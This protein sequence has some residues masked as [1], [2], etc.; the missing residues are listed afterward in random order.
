MRKIFTTILA[1]ALIFSLVA[2]GSVSKTGIDYADAESF[3]AAL[4][5]GE[6]LEG[7]VVQFVAKELYPN[8]A[9]GYIVHAGDH[10]NFAS[11]KNPDIKVGDTVVVKATDISSLLGSWIIT[12]EKV[13]NAKITDATISSTSSSVSTSAD[14][15][16]SNSNSGDNTNS[17][18]VASSSNANTK[19]TEQ[20]LQ[21]VDHGCALSSTLGDTAYIDFCGMIYNPNASL[22]VEFPKLLVTVKNGDGSI[23]ATDS[24]TGYLI[25]PGDTITLCGTFAMPIADLTDDAVIY[26]DIEWG[27]FYSESASAFRRAKTTD[28][29][30]SNISERNGSWN[31]ITG[32]ITNNYSENIDM[33]DVVVILRKDGEIVYIDHTYVD[34]VKAGQTKAFE[35]KS[36]KNWP[37]HDTIDIS[38]SPWM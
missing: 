1:V 18:R 9:L 35:F 3:E 11:S 2:C 31:Y 27:D 25:Q 5:A 19:P 15:S 36:Y 38:C 30:V 20:P 10:L 34:S 13:N 28:F 22:I 33:V 29:V 4:D 26:Y 14:E 32:E 24:Q 8:S 21:I 6:N 7:K 23:L 16:N 37:E 17:S 12:Y